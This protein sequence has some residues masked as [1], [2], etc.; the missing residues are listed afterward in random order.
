MCAIFIFLIYQDESGQTRGITKSVVNII[1][2]TY[3]VA[4]NIASQ[5]KNI[6]SDYIAMKHNE[7]DK[8]ID[9]ELYVSE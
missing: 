8:F 1:R 3:L 7:N 2:I 4:I 5:C 9:T 6:T